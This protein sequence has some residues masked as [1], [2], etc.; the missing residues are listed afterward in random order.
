MKPKWNRPVQGL[1]KAMRSPHGDRLGH[2]IVRISIFSSS[3]LQS[4]HIFSMAC[5][6][7]Q[8]LLSAT[9]DHER[10]EKMRLEFLLESSKADTA[11]CLDVALPLRHSSDRATLAHNPIAPGEALQHT[12]ATSLT[13]PLQCGIA[14]VSDDK[15]GQLYHPFHVLFPL[16]SANAEPVPPKGRPSRPP[17]STLMKFFIMYMRVVRELSWQEIKRKFN[18]FFCTNRTLGGLTCE[19]YRTRQEYGMKKVA[20]PD[21]RME[22]DRDIIK[23][24]STI[25]SHEFLEAIR[26]VA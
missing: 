4:A 14:S 13:M 10:P 18:S 21:Y 11:Y 1:Q 6:R 19:Y 8:I 5:I 3:T 20:S 23:Y 12:G 9:S 15:S 26:F 16:D 17:Y 25:Y 7:Q 2:A 22:E 24:K